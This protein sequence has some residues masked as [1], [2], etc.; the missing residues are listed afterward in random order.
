MKGVVLRKVA[1]CG[2]VVCCESVVLKESAG[3]PAQSIF[4]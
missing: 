4:V 3:K 2:S 1:A